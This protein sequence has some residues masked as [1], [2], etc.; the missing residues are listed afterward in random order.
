[1]N[2][3]KHRGVETLKSRYGIM[4]ISPWI[5]GMVIFFI[6]P[7]FQSVYYSFAD[8][9]IDAE[10]AHTA[11]VGTEN[12]YQ[13]LAKDP[14]YLDNLLAAL[15]NMLISLP[16]ILIVSI[17]L[18]LLL[19][20]KYFGRTFFRGLYF[21]PVILSSG[22]VLGL[23]LEADASA[24]TQTDVSESISFNMINFSEVLSAFELPEQIENF[25]TTALSNI[26][27]LVWQSGIQ[28]VL[29]IA[30]LQSI[31]ETLYEV[32][33]VEGTTKWEE[34][35]YIT[36]PMLMR[37]MFLV[38]IFTIIELASANSN[39]VIK[40][41]YDQFNLMEYGLGSSMLWFYFIF[42]GVFVLILFAVYRKF[43][44]KK[45]G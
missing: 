35:W 21:L 31:P 4:F 22:V 34:F 42:V 39:E 1:M 33:K 45:W 25:F 13:I 6:V 12:F 10:G 40:S 28:T 19:N 7:I 23:F 38:I 2:V 16:F 41:G 24:A 26:F 29:L 36:F 30:G 5:L 11:F 9:A 27:L 43:F 37:T 15:S 8:I 17:V 32:A 14:K 20:G 44:L 3:K 18:A